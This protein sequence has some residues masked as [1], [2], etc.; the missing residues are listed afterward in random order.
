MENLDLHN[1]A[2]DV[3]YAQHLINLKKISDCNQHL[4]SMLKKYK[5]NDAF[6]QKILLHMAMLYFKE[7]DFK[8]ALSIFLEAIQLDKDS[9]VL[10]VRLLLKK[11]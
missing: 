7:N 9:Q 8:K 6:K 4:H 5:H 11:F 2:A 3:G 1:F 10:Q